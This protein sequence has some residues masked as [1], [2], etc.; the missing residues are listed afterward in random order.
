MPK[1]ALRR[2]PPAWLA[3]GPAWD[4]DLVTHA[5]DE[6]SPGCHAASMVTPEPHSFAH[7]WIRAWNKR[8]VEAVLRHYADDVVFTSPT[9]QRV[10]PESGGTIHGKQALRDYWIEALRGNEGLHFELAGVYQGVNT[11][12]LHYANQLGAFV[13]E[14]LTFR[15]GLVAVGHATHLR[16]PAVPAAGEPHVT[17][18]GPA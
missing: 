11:I 15:D 2:P 16:T 12:V 17:A 6:P 7:G 1:T 8:D 14:V 9:A 4:C 10:V 18:G 3:A 5:H 13:S